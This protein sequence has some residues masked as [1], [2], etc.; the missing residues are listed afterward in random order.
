MVGR[1]VPS[2]TPCSISLVTVFC[3]VT[4][5]PFSTSK[6]VSAVTAPTSRQ[7][8][9]SSP[10]SAVQP[11]AISYVRKSAKFADL[12]TFTNSQHASEPALTVTFGSLVIFLPG[13]I[14][15]SRWSLSVR[16]M[17]I[18][19]TVKVFV[20]GSVLSVSQASVP[21]T[22]QQSTKTRATTESQPF[23]FILAPPFLRIWSPDIN[24]AGRLIYQNSPA[25]HAAAASAKPSAWM[26]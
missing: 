12:S 25:V 24:K 5:F 4:L 10:V 13:I 6:K 8:T 17:S 14:F 11:S 16:S 7:N 21:P 19:P 9:P 26:A 23:F 18:S 15:R 3:T 2:F 20:T 1:S 22:A